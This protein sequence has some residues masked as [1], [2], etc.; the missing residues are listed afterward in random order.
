CEFGRTI[1]VAQ[2]W[3]EA[4]VHIYDQLRGH[5]VAVRSD[6][7]QSISVLLLLRICLDHL[8]VEH[9]RRNHAFEFITLNIIE[10]GLWV[11]QAMGDNSITRTKAKVYSGPT[12]GVE[13]RGGDLN[14]L[15][16]APR[17]GAHKSC[18]HDGEDRLVAHDALRNS[19]GARRHQ[20]DHS[21][22]GKERQLDIAK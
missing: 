17:D 20:H 16:R 5:G 19:G 8:F 12:P 15:V 11:K 21:M 3:P 2:D 4:L 6:E 7:A 14:L 1:G 22:M 9:S 10:H 18:H 13:H